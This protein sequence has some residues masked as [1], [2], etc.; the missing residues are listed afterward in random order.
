MIV[1]SP[2]INGVYLLFPTSTLFCFKPILHERGIREIISNNLDSGLESVNYLT[3]DGTCSILFHYF[4]CLPPH[5]LI[6]ECWYIFVT[7]PN[8][9]ADQFLGQSFDGI[10]WFSLFGDLIKICHLIDWQECLHLL[11]LINYTNYCQ[12]KISYIIISNNINWY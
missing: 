12:T 5:K 1:S 11:N 9:W 3:T 6:E 8:R 4:P 2:T 7:I 10:D